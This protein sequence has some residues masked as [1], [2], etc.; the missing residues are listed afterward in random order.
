MLPPHLP[1]ANLNTGVFDKDGVYW[2]TGQN[3]VYGSVNAKT[4]KVESWKSPR[5]GSYGITVTPGND[6]WYASLA[7]DHL[8]KIDKA[9]GNVDDRR[10]AQARRRP[11]PRL[12]GL[13]G[14]PLGELLARRRG[15]P[16]RSRGEGLEDVAPARQPWQRLLFGLCRRAGQGLAH[17]FPRPTPS[18]ASTPPPRRSRASRAA[19]AARRCARCS[20]GPAKPGV[21][22]PA[23]T[24]WCKL[25]IDAPRAPR[26]CR[27]CVNLAV[28]DRATTRRN[29]LRLIA[30][31]PLLA[32]AS[33]TAFAAKA[34]SRRAP[35]RAGKGAADCLAA[36][37]FHFRQAAWRPLPGRHADRRPETTRSVS[38]SATMHSI[39]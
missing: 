20:A 5:G 18:S 25:S 39:A 37:R 21:P 15:R 36:D 11:A 16:L 22:N 32:A 8:G 10:A 38:S 9:T 7:G 12:V 13:Q 3:G 28:M 35:D 17:R 24:G 1:S 23:T 29:I 4:G 30:C 34:A 33:R 26:P 31:S 6:V 19:S 27:T 14:H 2:F